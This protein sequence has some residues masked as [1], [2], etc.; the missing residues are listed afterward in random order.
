MT[1]DELAGLADA[2]WS[3]DAPSG[4]SCVRDR[5]NGPFI[6]GDVGRLAAS[7]GDDQGFCHSVIYGNDSGLSSDDRLEGVCGMVNAIG[8]RD[9]I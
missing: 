6:V 4:D 3:S 2:G 7:D 5:G 8:T 1:Q 9:A